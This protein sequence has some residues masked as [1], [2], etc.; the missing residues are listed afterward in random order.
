MYQETR[1]CWLIL[2]SLKGKQSDIICF[3]LYKSMQHHLYS[4]QKQTKKKKPKQKN[5]KNLTLTK[6]LD[7]TTNL[8]EI[9][10]RE[11]QVK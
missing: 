7:I 5:T 9:W 1:T 2:A 11:E 10:G 8:Q 6:P 4:C 3:I